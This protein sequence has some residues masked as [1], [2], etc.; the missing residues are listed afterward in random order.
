MALV[1]N[2]RKLNAIRYICKADDAVDLEASDR[3]LYDED[4]VRNADALKFHKGKEPTIFILN[5][6]V[7][8]REDAM[9][10]D[11]RIK[12]V[13]E[14]KQP[15][16]SMGKWAYTVTRIC[17]KDIQNPPGVN[18]LVEFKKEGKGYVAER[19]MD[20]LS[21]VGVVEEIWQLFLSLRENREAVKAE[22]KN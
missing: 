13:D 15:M 19:V 5:F 7:T 4:P 1:A 18:P 8:G 11:A 2:E 3:E 17:L 21:Q 9:I 16:I 20:K 12:G 6:D 22:A 14:D 10:K